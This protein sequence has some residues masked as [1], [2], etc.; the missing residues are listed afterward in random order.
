MNKRVFWIVLIAVLYSSLI[1]AHDP[2]NQSTVP[3]Y[4]ELK[5]EQLDFKN[6]NQKEDGN[7]ATLTLQHQI[8]KHCY[9]AAYEK[10]TTQTK[11]PPM[12]EDLEVSKIY[13]KYTYHLNENHYFNAGYITVKDNIVPTDGGKVYSLGY[14][15]TLNKR[16]NLKIDGY[17]SH[18]DIFN[19]YQADLRY[20]R[21]ALI[22][23]FKTSLILE[24]KY[25]NINN[26]QDGF[27][28][29]AQENYFTPGI[30]LKASKNGYFIHGGA[31][32]G[33]RAFAVINDGFMLQ[34]H[35]ME[36][37]KIYMIGMGKRWKQFGLKIRY[38][39]Q[40]AKELPYNNDGV[41]VTNLSAMLTYYF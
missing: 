9:K 16:S 29:N 18:Y 19:T 13:F 33:K 23:G 6:S 5:L 15:Y 32:F 30:R 14:S 3:S 24:A 20:Q 28:A 22:N 2:K 7:R 4:L 39:S 1:Y 27:C 34:H 41:N 36:F 26:C 38:I 21:L 12:R 11:Q 10:A 17:Y 40:E 25:I 35:A 31:F 37:S 8:A